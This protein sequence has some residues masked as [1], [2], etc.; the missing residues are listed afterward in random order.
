MTPSEFCAYLRGLFAIIDASHKDPAKPHGLRPEQVKL[1]R[2]E[3]DKV[4]NDGD[5]PKA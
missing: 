4:K 2:S 3:L 1:I 5:V